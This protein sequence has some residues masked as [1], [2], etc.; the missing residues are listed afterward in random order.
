MTK[1]LTDQ[2]QHLENAL[3][4]T[5]AQLAVAQLEK[6]SYQSAF[7]EATR[8][9]SFNEEVLGRLQATPTFKE[10][11]LEVG[12]LSPNSSFRVVGNF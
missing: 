5:N 9:L 11:E 1:H 7:E 6:Q 3:H 12:F 10:S 2:I 8:Q 4:L